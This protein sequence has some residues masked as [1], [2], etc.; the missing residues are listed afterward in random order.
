MITSAFGFVQRFIIDREKKG[1]K[2][3]FFFS[4]SI[5]IHRMNRKLRHFPRENRSDLE[6]ESRARIAFNDC[7]QTI[8]K[9]NGRFRELTIGPGP[10]NLTTK[11]SPRLRNNSRNSSLTSVPRNSR[12]GRIEQ[13]PRPRYLVRMGQ[14]QNRCLRSPPSLSVYSFQYIR[15]NNNNNNRRRRESEKIREKS[16]KPPSSFA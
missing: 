14:A 12:K 6:S 10:T 15:D 2:T 11:V 9:K 3:H 7:M 8:V 13:K 16:G 5:S 4:S 1:L